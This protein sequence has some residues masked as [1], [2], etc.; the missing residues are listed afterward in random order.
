MMFNTGYGNFIKR[1]SNDEAIKALMNSTFKYGTSL[2]YHVL[3]IVKKWRQ[4]VE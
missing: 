3:G 2:R 4:D 1:S